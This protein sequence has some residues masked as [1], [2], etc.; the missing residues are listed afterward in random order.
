M[1]TNKK[2]YPA[3]VSPA[4]IY[5]YPP[6]SVVKNPT[7]CNLNLALCHQRS[8]H[9][10]LL[11]LLLVI[12]VNKKRGGLPIFISREVNKHE[13]ILFTNIDPHVDNGYRFLVHKVNLILSYCK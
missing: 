6:N 4:K 1:L 2:L 7:P 10:C 13:K 8:K 12:Y 3:Y 11:F 9:F 5:S